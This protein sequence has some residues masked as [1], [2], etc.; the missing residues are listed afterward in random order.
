MQEKNRNTLLKALRELPEHTPPDLVW[1]AVSGD[2]DKVQSEIPLRRAISDLPDHEPPASIW[3]NISTHF[4]QDVSQSEESLHQA[5]RELPEYDPPSL[6]W[7]SI[8]KELEVE[9][10]EDRRDAP[11]TRVVPLWRR[12][13]IAASMTA[14][15]C[16]LAW[17]LFSPSG[18]KVSIAYSTIE[19]DI[20]AA[21]TDQERDEIAFELV[22]YELEQKLA[23]TKDPYLADL[24]AELADLDLAKRQ[25]QEVMS[26][27][28][29]DEALI[30][31]ITNIEHER[32]A[33]LKE[34][35]TKI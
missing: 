22:L 9:K 2:L 27:Y 16:A 28:G 17:L 21:D 7:E 25:V 8:Q 3:E 31:Q 13:T 6:V 10:D 14:L 34:M 20:H 23:L 4:N 32:S 24:K 1:K 29:E 35:V 26:K 12:P 18:D 33:V 11:V 19:V 30:A 15:L 5:I